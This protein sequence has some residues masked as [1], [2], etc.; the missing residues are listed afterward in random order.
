[1]DRVKILDKYVNK[2]GYTITNPNDYSVQFNHVNKGIKRF[3]WEF[4][5]KIKNVK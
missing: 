3:V 2:K 4:I 5:G 1:M